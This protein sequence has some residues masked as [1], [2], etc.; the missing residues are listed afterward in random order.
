MV[1]LDTSQRKFIIRQS[2]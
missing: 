1:L 2:S